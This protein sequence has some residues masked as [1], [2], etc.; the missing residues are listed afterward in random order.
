MDALQYDKVI[1]KL[2]EEIDKL[3]IELETL[4]KTTVQMLSEQD[5]EYNQKTNNM[6][7]RH[8]IKILKSYNNGLETA[9]RI[10]ESCGWSGVAS[11]AT[12]IR[13]RFLSMEGD[14]NV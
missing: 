14:E 10:V 13:E 6:I 1:E 9:A 3:K 4:K 2:E 8:A 11:P 12:R 7:E 5:Y